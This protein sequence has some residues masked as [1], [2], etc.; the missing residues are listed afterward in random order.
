MTKRYVRLLL[1]FLLAVNGF[2]AFTAPSN[3]TPRRKPPT[4]RAPATPGPDIDAPPVGEPPP[5]LEDEVDLT[6]L[7]DAPPVTAVDSISRLQERFGASV[8]EELPRE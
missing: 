5:E 2:P 7:R 1:A 6:E 3:A 8:V 4:Q